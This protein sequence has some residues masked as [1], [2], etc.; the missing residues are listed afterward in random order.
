MTGSIFQLDQGQAAQFVRCWMGPSLGWQDLPVD[1]IL[2]V[3]APGP[4]TLPAYA[5][6]VLLKALATPIQLPPVAQWMVASLP[7][8]NI[9]GFER[10]IFIKDLSGVAGPATPVVVNPNGGETID[11]LPSYSII[12]TNDCLRLYGLSDR[13]GWFSG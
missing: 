7:L 3:T 10:G 1:P 12:T 6:R 2:E 8:A 4:L 9:S 13:S 5:N 11:Q